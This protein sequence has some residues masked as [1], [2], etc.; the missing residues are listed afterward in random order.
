M[1]T[2]AIS[3]PL[4]LVASMPLLAGRIDV[5]GDSSAWVHT[6]ANIEIQFGIWNYGLN[7]PGYS[8]YP[9]QIGVQVTGF[10]PP[11]PAATIPGTTLQYFEGFLFQGWLES[12]DGSTAVPFYDANAAL[13]GLPEGSILVTPGTFA[14]GG[15]TPLDIAVMSA[16][17]TL[18]EG[19]SEAL[20]GANAGSYSSGALIRLR[21]LGEGFTIGIGPGYTVQTAV[22]VPGITGSGP[23][24]TSGITGEVAIAN[25]EPSTW[26]TLAG[27]LAALAFRM[28]RST[29][30]RS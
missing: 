30:S 2:I 11:S 28:R 7:N 13:L 14:A 18:S 20:F 16:F 23:A 8:P 12:L 29:R 6:G 22:R 27:A 10:Q 5:T 4:L 9:T 24:Q 3:F 19:V 21:N 25:P 17:A 1:K 26:L 15:S